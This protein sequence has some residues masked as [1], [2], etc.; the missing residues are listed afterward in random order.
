MFRDLFKRLLNWWNRPVKRDTPAKAKTPARVE[1]TPS[2]EVNI[3][4]DRARERTGIIQPPSSGAG[5]VLTVRI[6]LDF[7]TAFTKAAV[8]LADSAFPVRWSEEV[9]ADG[10]F[11][12]GVISRMSDGTVRLGGCTAAVEQFAAL[13]G[14]FLPGGVITDVGRARTIAFAALVLRY[15]RTFVHQRLEDFVRGRRIVWLLNV[16]CPTNVY[17]AQRLTEEY[18]R[19]FAIAWEISHGQTDIHL[20]DVFAALASQPKPLSE[21]GLESIEAIPEFVA[22]VAA[23]ARSPQR[24]DGLHLLVD[25]GAGTLDIATFNVCQAP[26]TAEDIYPILRSEVVP[27]GTHFLMKAFSRVNA[28]AVWP[29][30]DPFPVDAELRSRFG[31]GNRDIYQVK[32]QFGEKIRE[33]V[34]RVLRIT[35]RER[36]PLAQAWF[37]GLPV[38]LSGGGSSCGI[39]EQSVAKACAD[40]PV[41]KRFMQFP[42]PGSVERSNL[43]LSVIEVHRLSVAFGL[44]YD[45]EVIGKIYRSDETENLV[46]RQRQR[47][48]RDELYAK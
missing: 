43:H 42:L 29:D 18:R 32:I 45:P 33:T 46:M 23:Y 2:P 21:I 28:R 24:Q 48:D 34:L 20:R 12:P 3:D 31:L 19:I 22:Q 37:S 25:C 40:L 16:G 41:E 8:A 4:S 39:Y 26:G 14:P 30:I 1:P 15:C 9:G 47:P 10:Y 35:K 11:L 17:D 27:L 38:F 36:S 5:R 13:K 6:G 44:T 7:G